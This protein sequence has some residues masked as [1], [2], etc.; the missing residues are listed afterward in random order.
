MVPLRVPERPA[1]QSVL[2]RVPLN[3]ATPG[4]LTAHELQTIHAILAVFVQ[5]LAG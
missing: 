1:C 3:Q 2:S 5:S 4:I